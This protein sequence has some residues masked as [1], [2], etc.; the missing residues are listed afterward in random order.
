[1][2]SGHPDFYGVQ[3]SQRVKTISL[4]AALL[5]FYV[6][7]VGLVAIGLLLSVGLFAAGALALSGPALARFAAAVVALSALVAVL[8]FR[9]ARR[10]GAASILKRLQAAPPERSDRYHARFADAVEEIAIACGRRPVRAYVLPFSAFN[11]MAL[12]EADGTPAVAA[13]EGLLA[14]ASRDEM[15]A[16]VAHELAHIV[17]GDALFVTMV[18]SLA[19]LFDRVRESLE[20]E[21]DTPP[22]GSESAGRGG[23][24]AVFLYLAAFVS[25]VVMRLLSTLISREREVLA[26]A[27]AVEFGRDPA[28]LARAIYKAH[29]RKAFVGDFSAGYGPL[30]IVSPRLE[31]ESEGF[32]SRLVSTHPPVMTR[33]RRLAAMAH[34]SGAEII[35]QVH[36]EAVER[37]EARVELGSAPGPVPPRGTAAAGAGKGCPR[38]RVPLVSSFYEGVAVQACPSCRGKLVGQDAMD[39]ILARRE[40]GFGPDLVAKARAFQAHFL[41]NPVEVRK[42]SE[43][44]GPAAYCPACGY[45]M[46]PR[47]YNYQYYVPVDKCGS[48]RGIWFDA[49]ELE[50]LQILVER[51]GRF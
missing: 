47:P 4:F 27:A 1:M 6:F 50:I 37:A 24:P 7:A 18:C 28:A 11:S 36:E 25:S 2:P 31:G 32:W 30:F 44:V 43:A 42:I 19:G 3:R 5:L 15:L 12:I 8:H 17:R 40:V 39:R 10:S 38:C 21:S 48:C 29:V 13:T 41:E 23:V 9:E 51:R 33:V 34:L 35:H 49:D 26:D 20:P 22:D 16:V 45:R 46:R 14:E